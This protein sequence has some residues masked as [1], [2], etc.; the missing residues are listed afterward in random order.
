M[1]V[2]LGRIRG[3]EPCMPAISK[4]MIINGPRRSSVFTGVA[5]LALVVLST[6][7]IAR[8]AE[9]ALILHEESV[10]RRPGFQKGPLTASMSAHR[11]RLR[12]TQQSL[13]R[14]LESRHFRVTGSTQVLV[15]AVFVH[16]TRDRVAELR[17]LP[18]VDR[19]VFVPRA[20]AKLNAAVQ[21]IDAPA[22]WT[23]LGGIPNA[24]LGMKIADLDTGIEPTH[25]AF[26]NNTL[27][28]VA[29]LRRWAGRSSTSLPVSPCW[30]PAGC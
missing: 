20:R 25:P 5:A 8:G 14:E 17:S 21:L 24:G 3:N 16:S 2:R 29:G 1:S 23:F 10:A 26:I 18:G 15:N 13:R 6:G 9:Y 19:V 30:R 4:I 11:D 28:A 22:A 12:S 7:A 27:P